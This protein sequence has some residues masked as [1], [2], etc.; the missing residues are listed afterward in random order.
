MKKIGL[1]GGLAWV[2]TVQYYSGIHRAVENADKCPDK[3]PLDSPLEMC[4]ESLDLNT[5]LSFLGHEGDESSW[6]RFDAYHRDALLRLQQAGAECAA[7]ASNTPHAR[8]ESIVHDLDMPVVDMFNV[9]AEEA[10]RHGFE[11]V[12]IL[13]TPLTMRS[14]RFRKVLSSY[15]IRSLEV[16]DDDAISAT[17]EL[18]GRLQR[19]SAQHA[20]QSIE[21][22]VKRLW[23]APPEAPI[24][25]VLACTELP[26]AFQQN[27]QAPLLEHKGIT[28]LNPTAI[29]IRAILDCARQTP[30]SVIA[31]TSTAPP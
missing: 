3:P 25:V 23:N 21:T 15:G 9:V 22:I 6:C 19:G 30:S 7:I 8:F 2:S 14:E 11:L 10:A 17:F 5:A 26:L 24:C 12:L 1:V 16:T 31:A 18:I 20:L 27:V 29:H 13:G 4:I 28:Y